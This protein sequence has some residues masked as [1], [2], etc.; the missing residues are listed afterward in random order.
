MSIRNKGTWLAAGL[1]L[2]ALLPLGTSLPGHAATLSI[3]VS[4]NQLMDAGGGPIQVRG[5][6]RSGTEYA[7][8]QGF[9]PFDGP[10][11]AASVQAIASW[12]VNIV[13]VLLNEDCW[14]GINGAPNG[15]YSAA[16]YQQDIVNYV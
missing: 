2:A 5:V 7:C 14:L 12:H 1:L 16:T 10:S 9:G 13:R 4:G 6:N 11:D 3:S 8:V 15:G